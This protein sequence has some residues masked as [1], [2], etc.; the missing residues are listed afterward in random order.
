MAGFTFESG[1]AVVP[2]T[3]PAW[4][5]VFRHGVRGTELCTI[6]SDTYSGTVSASLPAGLTGGSYEVVVEGMTAE[7]YRK[8]SLAPGTPLDASLHLWWKDAPTGVL[9]GLARFTGLDNPLSATTPVPPDGSL[10]A[11]LRVDR[12]WRRPGPRRIDVVA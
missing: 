5:V 3:V 7:D 1:H 4:A 12:L 6:G 10:V 11:E 9:G 2:G 8:I